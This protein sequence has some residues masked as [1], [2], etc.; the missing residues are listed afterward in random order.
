MLAVIRILLIFIIPIIASYLYFILDSN[1]PSK[2][3]RENKLPF[4]LSNIFLS[5]S[6]AAGCIGTDVLDELHD[7]FVSH[8][9]A[10]DIAAC[11]H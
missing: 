11:R 10:Q 5:P 1:I 6:P 2:R 8:H 7:S 4:H 3:L 9:Q